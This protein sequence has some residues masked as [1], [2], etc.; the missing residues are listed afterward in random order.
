MSRPILGLLISAPVFEDV[1]GALGV[2]RGEYLRA[3][4]SDWICYY[5]RF[6]AARGFRLRWYLF[7]RAVR[8]AESAR[9]EPTG[10]E[11]RFLPRA[12]LYNW[13]TQRLPYVWRFRLHLATIS[14][15]FARELRE[16][17]PDLLW[18]Q[19]YESGRFDVASILG[20]RHGVPVVGQFH[21][22]HSPARAPLRWLRRW[23]LRRAALILAPNR[24][25]YRR[26]RDTYRLGDRAVYFP[27]PVPVPP[28]PAAAVGAV[29]A[30]L[31][32][33]ESDRYILFMGRIDA[34]KGLDRLLA[35]FRRLAPARP[36]LH[37]VVAGDGPDRRALEADAVDVGRVRFLGWVYDRSRVSALY[38]AATVVAC[39]SA[40]EAFS[41]GATEAMAVG[42][43]VV[44]SAVGGLLDVVD[45][46]RTGLL[47]PPGDVTALADAIVKLLDDPELAREMGQAG[48]ARI[49]RE[50]AEAVLGPRLADHLAAVARG[51]CR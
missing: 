13:W 32:L 42:R 28:A 34:N 1:F 48:R 5:S 36:G 31:G 27:N 29:K 6:L 3:Y 40:S 45:H 2:D 26:V 18:V 10:A 35:A 44:A 30:E 22:G 43:P 47:V 24:E 51:R 25:E 8:R 4:D 21:G 7:S 19:D 50:F 17:P 37:L 20:A 23:S 11:V 33:A 12:R 9:H 15:A 46:G 16:R 39:P 14:P 49:E 38:G 41:Y